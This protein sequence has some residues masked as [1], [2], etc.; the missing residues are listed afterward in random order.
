VCDPLPQAASNALRKLA[1]Q[2]KSLD[3]DTELRSLVA[4]T[5]GIAQTAPGFLAWID[6]FRN[7]DVNRRRGFDYPLLPPEAA[8]DPSKDAVSINPEVVLRDQFA[9]DSP[10]VRGF[11][12]AL[13]ELL[14]GDG[15]KQ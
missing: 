5:Y 1:R 13:A 11:F 6:G 12:D 10:A 7:W 2:A 14:T 9:R 15:R 3:R 4:A 8:T